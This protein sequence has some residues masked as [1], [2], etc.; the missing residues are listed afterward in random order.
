M[1]ISSMMI[2]KLWKKLEAEKNAYMINKNKIPLSRRL[3]RTRRSLRK[4]RG[5][6]ETHITFSK[7]IL[8]NNHLLESREWLR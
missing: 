3:G 1:T 4:S 7:T 6:R 8:K 2:L 5:R